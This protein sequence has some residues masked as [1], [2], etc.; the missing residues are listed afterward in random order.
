MNGSRANIINNKRKLPMNTKTVKLLVIF[1]TPTCLGQKS[2]VVANEM[3]G[4]DIKFIWSCQVPNI[5]YYKGLKIYLMFHTKDAERST[6]DSHVIHKIQQ[7]V[8]IKV[9]A[10]IKKEEKSSELILI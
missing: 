6:I 5:L 3:D 4:G 9:V 10:D 7:K 2:F 1:P 8:L